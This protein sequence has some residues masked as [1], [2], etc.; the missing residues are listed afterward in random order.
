V[1]K[2]YL[3]WLLPLAAVPV[4]ALLA[5]GF[6]VNHRDIPSPLVNRPA[7]KFTLTSYTG[8]PMSLEAHRGR[9][10]VVNFW[11]SWCLACRDEHPALD[12][13]WRRYRDRGVVVVGVDFEDTEEAALAYVSEMGGDWPLVTDPGSRTAIAYGVFGVPETFVI[14]PDGTIA[15]KTIGAVT[16]AWL[17][18]HI[19]AALR[20]GEG[21]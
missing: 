10:V 8:E 7:A 14:A 2:T 20:S 3:R 16:Y 11:A 6:T 1:K 21:R 19:D 12:E 9:V 5:Y 4:L 18:E 13:A 15:A 17:T